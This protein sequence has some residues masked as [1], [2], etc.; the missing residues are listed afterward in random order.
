MCGIIG[1]FSLKGLSINSRDFF[2]DALYCDALRG[3]DSTGIYMYSN[4]RKYEN[5][6]IKKP[7]HALDFLWSGRVQKQLSKASQYNCLIG[8]NRAATR[9]EINIEN[10]HPFQDGHITLVHNGTLSDK[11]NLPDHTNYSV[12]SRAICHSV[13][14][15]GIDETSKLLKGSYALVWVDHKDMTLNFL[16]NDQ[17]PMHFAFSELEQALYWASEEGMLRWIMDRNKIKDG[18]VLKLR[19]NRLV[20][21]KLNSDSISFSTRD[22]E[23]YT[24]PK[25]LGY[26]NRMNTHH[27]TSTA[28]ITTVGTT[29]TSV[30]KPTINGQKQITKSGT[31]GTPL[32]TPSKVGLVDHRKSPTGVPKIGDLLEVYVYAREVVRESPK[33][34]KADGFSYDAACTPCEFHNIKDNKT[35]T[36]EGT[37]TAKVVNV[38]YHR[39]QNEHVAYCILGHATEL[40]NI[41]FTDGLVL[42]EVVLEKK[43]EA[44]TLP[45]EEK[46][47]NTWAEGLGKSSK[48]SIT[49]W[50]SQDKA[51][52]EKMG[53]LVGKKDVKCLGHDSDE[54]AVGPRSAMISIEKFNELV[55]YGCSACTRDLTI[56]DE[57]SIYWAESIYPVCKYCCAD[58]KLQEELNFSIPDYIVASRRTM[59]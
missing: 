12:D 6:V 9:G 24:I 53:V 18:E 36:H 38:V 22:V 55:A 19:A 26:S 23:P 16:R 32:T 33:S 43:S 25:Y 57:F 35:C 2:E 48:A 13:N 14:K 47:R 28:P 15:I 42:K 30:I 11:S 58:V 51:F 29:S 1:V 7:L 17:R 34:W 20:S 5:K 3:V 45:K 39:D 50:G 40:D 52:T 37:Y 4:D 46:A 8:H 49:K 44:F 59:L 41:P 31:V 27:K 56:Q 10:S 54:R 21:Y